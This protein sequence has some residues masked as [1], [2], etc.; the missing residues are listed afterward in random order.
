MI[1][2]FSED[3]W[4]G[5]TGYWATQLVARLPP[6]TRMVAISNASFG[7]KFWEMLVQRVK[8]SSKMKYFT[9][10]NIKIDDIFDAVLWLAENIS[11]NNI[12]EILWLNHINRI[13]L[14]NVKQWGEALMNNN[15]LTQLYLLGE[16]DD[17]KSEPRQP[18]NNRTLK[19]NID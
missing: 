17:I 11:S 13:R 19:L 18:L 8:K 3:G 7:R 2:Y 1:F 4:D 15:T 16:D 12:I 14:N 9:L 10:V 6:N 5:L